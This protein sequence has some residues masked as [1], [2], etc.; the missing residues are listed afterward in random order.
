M[1]NKEA[2]KLIEYY[3][4]DKI[5]QID[6]NTVAAFNK[7]IEALNTYECKDEQ[8]TDYSANCYKCKKIKECKYPPFGRCEFEPKDEPQKGVSYSDHTD[9]DGPKTYVTWTEPKTERSK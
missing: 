2:I 8:Q 3:L 5:D 1:T 7:A 6:G 4:Y 9:Y